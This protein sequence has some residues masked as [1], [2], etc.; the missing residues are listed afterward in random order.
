MTYT[1][2]KRILNTICPVSSEDEV[3]VAE[4]AEEEEDGDRAIIVAAIVPNIK[5]DIHQGIHT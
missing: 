5:Y 4:V 1:N 3:V 2:T